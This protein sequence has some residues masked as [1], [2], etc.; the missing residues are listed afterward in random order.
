[1]PPVLVPWAPRAER[2]HPCRAEVEQLDEAKRAVF[3]SFSGLFGAASVCFGPGARL[4]RA[5]I[6]RTARHQQRKSGGLRNR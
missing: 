1:M 4:A 6:V 2:R 3:W 5:T